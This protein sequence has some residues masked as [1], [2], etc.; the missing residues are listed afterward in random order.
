L[1]SATL[2][3]LAS[4]DDFESTAAAKNASH[5]RSAK[6]CPIGERPAFMM[7]GRVPP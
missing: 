4:I 2:L 7:I 6:A 1:I 3:A 5:F